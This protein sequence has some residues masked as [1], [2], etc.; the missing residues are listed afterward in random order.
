LSGGE[1]LNMM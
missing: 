1:N